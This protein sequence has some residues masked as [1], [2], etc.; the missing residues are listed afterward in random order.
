M[1]FGKHKKRYVTQ[2]TND[3]IRL[4]KLIQGKDT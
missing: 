4:V 2:N 3:T 1:L